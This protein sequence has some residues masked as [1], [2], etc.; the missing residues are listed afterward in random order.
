LTHPANDDVRIA[1]SLH[2]ADRL[3]RGRFTDESE[4]RAILEIPLS[5][6]LGEREGV[7]LLLLVVDGARLVRVQRAVSDSARITIK[8]ITTGS[9]APRRDLTIMCELIACS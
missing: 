2:D 9:A 5:A 4:G 7:D 6:R 1:A 3:G 8:R